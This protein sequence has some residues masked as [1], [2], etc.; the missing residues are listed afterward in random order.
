[1]KLGII[2]LTNSSK[3]NYTLSNASYMQ[4]FIKNCC[5]IARVVASELHKM[6]FIR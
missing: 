5:L 3:K 4:T 6:C 1:M 2:L